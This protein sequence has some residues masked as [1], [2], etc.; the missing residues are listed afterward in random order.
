MI[1]IIV[2]V[3]IMTDKA[4]FVKCFLQYSFPIEKKTRKGVLF[5]TQ[6]DGQAGRYQLL[7]CGIYWY[8]HMAVLDT[9]MV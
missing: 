6:L 9:G 1:L 3:Y 7:G 2:T 4:M 8:M 5:H